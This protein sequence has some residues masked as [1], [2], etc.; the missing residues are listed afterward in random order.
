MALAK[1]GGLTTKEICEQA[2][3]SRSTY[4]RQVAAKLT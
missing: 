3:C 2:G 1:E 4:Y